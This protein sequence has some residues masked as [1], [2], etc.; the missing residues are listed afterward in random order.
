MSGEFILDTNIVIGLFANDKPVVSHLRKSK[1]IFVPS[2]VIGEL[3]YGAYNSHMVRDNIVRLNG[4]VESVNVLS[5]D[6]E[7]GQYYG[8]IKKELKDKGRP[9]PENDIWISSLALQHKLVLVSRDR[10]F[11]FIDELEHIIW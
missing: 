7:T 9:I 6:E 3:Y 8:M 5:C 1:T 10:H 11:S 2:I 4:F